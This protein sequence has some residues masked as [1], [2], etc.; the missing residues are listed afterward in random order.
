MMVD[1]NFCLSS[2]FAYR[3][4]Y[5]DG[6]DFM[7][8]KQHQNFVPLSP[9]EKVIVTSAQDIDKEIQ[10]QFNALYEKY[11]NIGILL[12]G[13]MDSAILA[14]YL[15]PHS[16]AYTFIAQGTEVFDAD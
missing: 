16:R 8:G 3:Y 14:S 2:Y 9:K 13:G 7:E 12:S 15:K 1:K 5:K 6:V 4:L 11:D 10:Q